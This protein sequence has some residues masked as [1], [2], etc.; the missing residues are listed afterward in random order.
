V[1]FDV[2]LNLRMAGTPT[3]LADLDRVKQGVGEV[4]RSAG[5]A[6]AGASR[7][8]ASLGSV[9]SYA[10][11]GGGLALLGGILSQASK[12]L[13]DASVNA[14]RLATGLNFATGGKSAE[15]LAYLRRVTNEL[16]LEFASS[17]K[18]YM[19]FAAAARNTSLEGQGARQVFE[20]LSKASAVMGLSANQTEGA[21]LAL[22][23]MVSKGTVS[24]EE[25]RG[26]LGER[27]PG[28]FQIAARAM[29]VTTQELG[30]ML[31]QGQVLSDDFLPKF[32]R[33][34]ETELGG[35]ADK[36]ADRLD[37]ATNRLAN[38]WERLKTQAGDAGVSQTAG[39]AMKALTADMTA[40]QEAM[41]RARQSGGGAL[42]QWN[43]AIGMFIGRALSLHTVSDA[44]KTNAAAAQS[45]ADKL[46]AAEAEMVTLQTR[47]V[48]NPD[49]I[50]LRSDIAQLQKFIDTAR[51]A[52]LARAKAAGTAGPV[53]DENPS[54]TARLARQ[55]KSAEEQAKW[56]AKYATDA[57]RLRDELAQ[58]RAAFNGVIPEDLEQRI[59]EKYIKPTREVSEAIKQQIA[60]EKEVLRWR[61]E[62][63]DEQVAMG[64]DEA[65]AIGDWAKAESDRR[66]KEV[67]A[68]QEALE[69]AEFEYATQGMLR[70][71]IAAVTLQR[72][73]DKLKAAAGSVEN[74]KA[75]EAE[76]AAQRRLI[77]VLQ[78]G[79]ARDAGAAAAKAAESEWKRTA[80][81]IERSLTD[82]LLRGFESGKGFGENLRDT[83]VNMFRTLVLRPTIQGI[84]APIAG[85]MASVFG[86][87]GAAAS[88]GGG[89]VGLGTMGQGVSLY[90]FLSS[91]VSTGGVTAGSALGFGN[92]FTLGTQ[93][94]TS[95][96]TMTGFQTAGQLF[97]SGQYGASAGTA[98]GTV[99][100]WMAGVATGIYGGRAISGGYSSIGKSGNTA[101]NVGTAIGAIWG[102]IGA[103]IGGLIG[104]VVNRAFG[105]RPRE[106]GETGIDGTVGAG[107]FTGQ[108]YADWIEK[109]GWFR[110]DKR[111]TDRE[112]LQADVAAQL[113]GGIS[114]LYTATADYAKVLGLPVESVQRFTADFKVA[115]GK[116]E[117]ENQAALSKAM[118]NLSAQLIGVYAAQLAPL[119]RAGESLSDTFQRL[120]GLQVFSN[121]L[122]QLG[123]V[124]S[125]IANL[126]VE[127]KEQMI[128]LAG[129]IEAFSQQALGFVQN[130]YNR[131]EIAGLKA[132]EIQGVLQGA[133]ITTNINSREQFRAIVEGLDVGTEAGRKQLATLLGISGSFTSVADYL[134]ETGTTL[135][136][137]A[138]GAPELGNLGPLL[139]G[140]SQQVTATNEVRDGVYE[141]RDAID[142]LTDYMAGWG[143]LPGTDVGIDRRR[144]NLPEVGL[145]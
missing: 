100:P 114:A 29:G 62:V 52:E 8:S 99:A 1:A 37:A 19:G 128:G 39:S 76:I 92:S 110:S 144:I 91:G 120:L 14:Q 72:L 90:N 98:A 63:R 89:G 112:S 58:V 140:N 64:R 65:K 7:L 103:A 33:Q 68:A 107:G 143:G 80:E 109:G 119:Q 132:R 22:Q 124:F 32:A 139:A 117:E 44:F 9:A 106:Y 74:V 48:S 13:F 87:G 27:L 12:A 83:L 97:Q 46:K 130:Y 47:L 60:F 88:T 43:D 24:A 95:G 34:L 54:E 102:P 81:S 3:V 35:A 17:A 108:A 137:A 125:R 59:R 50:Y 25:L 79:E 122:N 21:L 55:A 69:R 135:N 42:R 56:F 86:M 96:S 45:M 113:N 127:A 115:W 123:G 40:V 133:G 2:A 73:E 61:K 71:Q 18:A 94:A 142:R 121:N 101:V 51:A 28:S 138:A 116:T 105:R 93:L 84:L 49:S 145:A 11:A 57:Q 31:E 131:D 23:Q 111:G 41:E 36:A 104:G 53:V 20:A 129:G 16:G 67:K 5:E 66:T 10:L 4:G 15:E 78:R 136:Q 38:A 118:E 85:G 26:Q 126:G 141:V 6:G 30:K 77:E 70:S 134:T 82:A 75:V